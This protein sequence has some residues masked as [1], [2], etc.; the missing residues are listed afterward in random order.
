MTDTETA[1]TCFTCTWGGEVTAVLVDGLSLGLEPGRPWTHWVEQDSTGRAASM[2]REIHER[3][4]AVDWELV[5]SRGDEPLGAHLAGVRASGGMLLVAAGTRGDLLTACASVQDARAG[6]DGIRTLVQELRETGQVRE[7]TDAR[8]LED[9]S[10]MNN[11]LITLQ[12]ERV[13]LS[14][15][16]ERSNQERNRLLGTLAHDLRSPLGVVLGYARLLDEEH[17][18]DLPSDARE[19]LAA[20]ARNAEYMRDLVNDVLDMAAVQ[21]GRVSLDFEVRD[22][23]EL[24]RVVATDA[25]MMARR[26][27][28]Q[29]VVE[30]NGD[31]TAEV[32][33]RRLTQAL[34]NL[35]DN[36]IKFGPRGS[37]VRLSVVR[38]PGHALLCVSDEGPGFPE[39]AAASI[40][41]FFTE[42]ETG[43]AG[44]RSTGLGLAIVRR[45][46]EAHGGELQV[47]ST[48]G[49][50]STICMRLPTGPV[51]ERHAR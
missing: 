7:Q 4:R 48:P 31:V 34:R 14:A 41:R 2:A 40:G 51:A 15:R 37:T 50:G 24:L 25:A 39:G 19:M 46:V 45:I 11:E 5:L 35:I 44:E 3:G 9:L 47:R 33:V 49:E 18:G 26:K 16:L 29:V 42:G 43:S 20:V 21:S 38:D 1:G 10:R 13:R 17:G 30:P 32:D 27:D 22:L 8:I 23:R 6:G 12:R 36:A 28:I